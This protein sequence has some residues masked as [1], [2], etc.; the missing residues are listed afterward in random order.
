MNVPAPLQ[1]GNGRRLAWKVLEVVLLAGGAYLIAQYQVG[2]AA[3]DVS[4]RVCLAQQQIVANET[5]VLKGV[6]ALALLLQD[7]PS[8]GLDPIPASLIS[9]LEN[10]LANIPDEAVC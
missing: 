5:V 4:H 2:L 10:A 9:D 6:F 3:R 7:R 8:A 1:N